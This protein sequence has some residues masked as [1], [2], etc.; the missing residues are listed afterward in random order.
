MAFVNTPKLALPGS[1]VKGDGAGTWITQW[2]QICANLE[3]R[4]TKSGSGTPVGLVAG[5]YVGQMY[6]RTD[7][8]TVYWCTLAG[9]AGVAT[10]TG[11]GS[12]A[13]LNTGTTIGQVPVHSSTG[14]LLTGA[15]KNHGD[16][17]GDLALQTYTGPLKQ[18]AYRDVPAALYAAK[19][20][21]QTGITTEAL[22][23]DLSNLTIPGSGTTYKVKAAV[24]VVHNSGSKRVF[25]LQIRIGTLGTL[26][27]AIFYAADQTIEFG[28]TALFSIPGFQ[29]TKGAN[30]KL[31]LTIQIPSGGAD[32][33]VLTGSNYY[34]FVEIEE[35]LV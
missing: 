22:I 33:N 29:F 10:W 9:I 32:L 6:Y 4:L 20:T 13:Y 15:Y 21:A 18:L 31:S 8:N 25:R 7:T 30:T 35:V 16:T 24:N 17:V 23:T 28:D 14:P 2:N 1:A 27:D 12:S 19:T 26:A 5:D 11:Y 34:S 3:A